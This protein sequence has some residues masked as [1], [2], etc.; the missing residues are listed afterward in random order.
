MN[1]QVEKIENMER[2]I[3]EPEIFRK[4]RV[5]GKQDQDSKIKVRRLFIC[6]E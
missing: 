5:E 6:S 3:E 2:R 1:N 4:T